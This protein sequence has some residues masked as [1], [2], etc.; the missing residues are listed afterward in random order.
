[1]LRLSLVQSWAEYRLWG[2]V[3]RHVGRSGWRWSHIYRFWQLDFK[4]TEPMIYALKIFCNMLL[5]YGYWQGKG[6]TAH[7]SYIIAGNVCFCDGIIIPPRVMAF[8]LRLWLFV[9]TINTADSKSL[10]RHPEKLAFAIEMPTAFGSV[11]ITKIWIWITLLSVNWKGSW[12][13]CENI[14]SFVEGERRHY[15][16]VA[17]MR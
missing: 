5:S 15:S 3:V 16:Y 2:V 1:M 6:L 4:L 9:W 11:E 8:V 7:Q 10:L 14:G 12:W 17:N 13:R